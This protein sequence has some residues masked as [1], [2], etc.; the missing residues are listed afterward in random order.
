VQVLA[1]LAA[2]VPMIALGRA[3][4]CFQGSRLRN[5]MARPASL[6]AVIPLHRQ[7]HRAI[8]RSFLMLLRTKAEPES[9]IQVIQDCELLGTHNGQML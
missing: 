2:Q 1:Q 4:F 3:L 8:C 6:F 9:G 7:W 5:A